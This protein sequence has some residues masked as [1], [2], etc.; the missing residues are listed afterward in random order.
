MS[1]FKRVAHSVA[2]GY[3]VLVL[4]AL[5]GLVSLR[6]ASHFLNEK[7]FG[8]WALMGSIGIYL[9]LVDMGMSGSVARLLID[10]KDE[11]ASGNYGSLIQTGWLVLAVQGAIIFCAGFF[12]APVLCDWLKIEPVWRHDFIVLL[13]WQSGILAFGFLAR[14]F[15]HLLYAH[16]RFDII[17]YGQIVMTGS[18]LV[19]LWFFFERGE[20]VLSSIWA[21]L[22]TSIGNAILLIIACGKLG[23][24]PKQWGKISWLHFKELF[25]YG[26]DMF[27]VS[28]GTQLI[29]FS[30]TFIITRDFGLTSGAAWNIG[31]KMFNLISQA[32]WKVSDFSAPAFSEMMARREQSVLRERYKSMVIMTASLSAFAAISY[33]LCNS[34]FV[35]LWMRGKFFWPVQN[36]LLLGGWMIVLAL[37]HC[38]NSFVLMTKRIASMRYIYFIEGVIFVAVAVMLAPSGGLPAIIGSS[39]VCSL[40]F[41]GTYG[42]W[43][44]KEYFGLSTKEVGLT[45]LQPMGKVLIAYAPFALAAWSL[46]KPLSIPLRF[47]INVLLCGGGGAFLFLRLGLPGSF[48]HEVLRRA[49]RPFVPLLRRIFGVAV[50]KISEAT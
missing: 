49:P 25:D 6:V 20:G 19:L 10:Y 36:D 11:Q 1:R 44:V 24:F 31:T 30:Q 21:N 4:V 38:H 8:L 14:I 32:I 26:K 37:L 28:V 12:L 5:T 43:R 47:A 35:T 15:N 9:N 2:S 7:E 46:E 33:V 50:P 18:N 45:W 16:Q 34:Y 27:L 23:L 3:A 48:H 29:M 39:I 41:S 42:L 13:R 22:A 17:N 40:V